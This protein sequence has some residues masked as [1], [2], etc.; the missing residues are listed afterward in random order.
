MEEYILIDKIK[1]IVPETTSQDM[2]AGF[3]TETEEDHQDTMSRGICK[4][5]IS[6][7]YP[8][9][10]RPGTLAGRKMEDDVN[11]ETKARSITRTSI[12]NKNTL[13]CACEELVKTEVLSKS[14]KEIN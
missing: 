7:I 10:E 1:A 6:V 3:P 13:G 8:Y 4:S 14:F 12:C 11:D 5:I 2:I 9:S